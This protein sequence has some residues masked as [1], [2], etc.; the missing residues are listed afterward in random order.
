MKEGIAEI[1][2]EEEK[3]RIGGPE[4]RGQNGE[5]AGCGEGGGKR[6]KEGGK[7]VGREEP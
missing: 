2:E 1:S 6:K 5:K 7:D 3:S 4:T